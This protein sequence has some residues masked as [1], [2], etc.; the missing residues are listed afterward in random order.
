MRSYGPWIFPYMLYVSQPQFQRILQIGI[1]PMMMYLTQ[2]LNMT[3]PSS[4]I[5]VSQYAEWLWNYFQPIHSCLQ[6]ILVGVAVWQIQIS[7]QWVITIVT[8]V[9]QMSFLIST[10]VSYLMRQNFNTAFQLQQTFQ[11]LTRITFWQMD[12]VLL[13]IWQALNHKML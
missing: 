7:K 6:V 11:E 5:L 8:N 12:F 2:Q 1:C 10:P 4:Y 9:E 3:C 13:Q